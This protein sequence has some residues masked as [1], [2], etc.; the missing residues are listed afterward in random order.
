LGGILDRNLN[1]FLA[2]N[3]GTRTVL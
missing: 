2:L 3:H 1:E